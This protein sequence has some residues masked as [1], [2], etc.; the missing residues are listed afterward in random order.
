MQDTDRKDAALLHALVAAPA[1]VTRAP[2]ARLKTMRVVGVV[3]EGADV[4]RMHRLALLGFLSQEVAQDGTQSVTTH[5]VT[6]LGRQRAARVEAPRNRKQVVPCAR[7]GEPLDD[8]DDP[9]SLDMGARTCHACV[10]QA[11]S[12]KVKYRKRMAARP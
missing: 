9:W 4:V 6:A 2:S 5:R 1:R 8:P 12:P 10:L 7:C 3:P 11:E